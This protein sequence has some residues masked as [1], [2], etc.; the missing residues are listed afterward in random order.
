MLSDV[1]TI[2]NQGLKVRAV[3]QFQACVNYVAHHS[4]Q[5]L[6]KRQVKER[7]DLFWLM[8]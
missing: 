7:G 8:A 3:L 2:K 6:D 1:V 4:D 5:T